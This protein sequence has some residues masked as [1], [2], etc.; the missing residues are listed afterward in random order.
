MITLLFIIHQE[1]KLHQQQISIFFLALSSASLSASLSWSLLVCLS[2]HERRKCSP[3][4][5]PW[6][7]VG[8]F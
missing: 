4:G 2:E 3:L 7:L 8:A 5:R 1:G 6:S